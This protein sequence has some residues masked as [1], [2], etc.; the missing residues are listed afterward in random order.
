MGCIESY[1]EDGLFELGWEGFFE[2]L[3]DGCLFRGC[4]Y[5]PPAPRFA[6]RVPLLLTQKGEGVKP[7]LSFG[8]FPH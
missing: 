3:R 2:D 1:P 7:P 8:H 6:R 4:G 5:D